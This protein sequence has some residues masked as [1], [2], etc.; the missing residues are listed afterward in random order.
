M[1]GGILSQQEIKRRLQQLRNVELLHKQAR[2]RII[3]QEKIISKQAVQIETLEK[4]NST[5]QARIEELEQIVSKLTDTKTRFRFFLFGKGKKENDNRSGSQDKNKLV[6]RPPQSYNRPKPSDAEITS[7]RKLILDSCPSCRD[8]VAPSSE[9]YTTYIEDIVFSPKIVTE[10]TIH[11]HWCRKCRKLVHAPIPDAIPGMHIGIHTMIYVLTEHYRARKTDEQI[12]DSLSRFFNLKISEGE[13]T[14]IR[15]KAADLFGAKYEQIIESIKNADVVYCDETGWKI[16]GKNAECWHLRAPNSNAARYI[17]TDTRG[18]GV[19]EE[20]L[21]PDF[22]GAIVSDFYAAYDKLSREHQV[23]WVHLLREANLL[24]RGQPD[25]KE[26]LIMHETL[27]SIYNSIKAFKQREWQESRSKY[28]N[29]LLTNRC[30]NLAHRPWQDTECQRIA[31]RLIKY[32]RELFTCIRI[33]YVLAENN[34]AERGIRPIVVHR[35]ITNGNRS[36]EGAR[37]YEINKSVIETLRMEG[38]DLI[39]SMRDILWQTAWARK[40]GTAPV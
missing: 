6:K 12:I 20:A 29:T 27:K 14:A 9:T 34:T 39:E 5:L 35:K 32:Q 4:H 11:R 17:M 24:A 3:K 40:L 7:R 21:G 10:Y 8:E 37:A 38:K 36:K 23:C 26:R 28:T 13:I 33:P 31:K 1:F 30:L 25:K 18:K 22:N 19:I 16:L 15:N 2:K